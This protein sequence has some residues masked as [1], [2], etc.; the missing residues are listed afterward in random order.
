MLGSL[1]LESFVE[2]QPRVGRDTRQSASRTW[3]PVRP[4]ESQRLSDS[5]QQIHHAAQL[6]AAAGI[7]FLKPAEDDSH[8]SLEWIPTLAGLFSRPIPAPTVFR[9]G[10]RPVDTALLIVT[11]N[12]KPFGEYRLHGKTITEAVDWIRS[13]ISGLG[14]DGSR[15][16]LK[17]HYEI[18]RHEVAIGDAF[19]ASDRAR[20]EELAKW[21][22]NGFA[23]LNSLARSIDDAS[24]VRCWPQHFD[25]ASLIQSTP[26]RTIGIGLE[27]GDE[28][29]E[30][31]YFYVNTH[32]QP[33]ASQVQTRPLWGRGSWHTHGW[34]GAVLPGS[35]L[36]PASAQEQQVRE[37]MDSAISACRGMAIQS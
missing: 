14:A 19:D 8:A 1:L 29:Y 30:E 11:E 16:T 34:I 33:R 17:R 25:I 28:Y 21:F 31:P 35:K 24:E 36:G 2:L 13:Q 7:S 10:V 37:F 27:A 5:R 4:E 6:A 26:D 15:Y 23:L 32:P 22:A 18:P 3:Q 20:F 9:I 12:D